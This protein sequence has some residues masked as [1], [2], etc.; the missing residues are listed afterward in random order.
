VLRRFG[1]LELI[2]GDW[3]DWHANVVN[4]LQLS[5]TLNA[6]LGRALL[7]RKL[8]TLR[9]DVPLF[10]NVD[11]LEWTGPTPAFEKLAKSLDRSAR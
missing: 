4:S 2:P 11:E 7:F 10:T 9:T 6:E 1:H 3:H 8:A 5:N